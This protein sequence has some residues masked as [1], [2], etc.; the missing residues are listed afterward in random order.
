MSSR[1]GRLS[2]LITSLGPRRLTIIGAAAIALVLLVSWMVFSRRAPTAA[3]EES[4][5]VVSVKVAQV[6]RQSIAE[7]QT[8]IGTVFPQH[9]AT[10]SAK[11]AA[12][13]KT[14]PLLR[15]KTFR[16]GDVVLTLESRDLQAQ[17][18]EAAAALEEA[19]LN[20]R[21]LSSGTI[22][23]TNAQDE[24]AVR[25]ATANVNNARAT[26]ERRR[27][28]YDQGGISKKDLEASQLAF[29]QAENDLR[30]AESTARLH[31]NATNPNERALAASRVKQA[32]DRLAAI[33]TQLSYA[34]IRA[35]F[36][37]IVTEQFQFQGEF[38][39]AGAKLFTISS[40][41]VAIVKAPFA[42]TV[43]AK[44]K[45]GDEATVYPQELP[46]EK[47]VGPIS[48][49]SRGSDQQ[50]RSVEVWVTLKDESKRLRSDSAAKVVVVTAEAPDAL[51]V[52]ASAVTL[53]A[54]NS[55]TGIVM[56]VDNESMAHETKVKVGIRTLDRFEITSGLK[57]GQTVVTEGGYALP[58]GTKVKVSEPEENDEDKDKEKDDSKK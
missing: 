20:E 6:Q 35:P 19:R 17:R 57:E 15:N 31:A 51:V 34:T 55:D 56:V 46:G 5:K 50:S 18:A 38:A 37:G 3:A 25:D 28:L 8:A 22:P 2:N 16:E 7:E 12:Q 47:M 26:L 41:G 43:A 29:T 52:P 24:K 14:M 13:I 58:D 11:I 39:S 44:L 23:Q 33:D 9:E 21:N 36:D 45:V 40:V 4:D 1:D 30:L 54:S 53:D 42:D 10:V 48:L 27:A 32:E 49:V